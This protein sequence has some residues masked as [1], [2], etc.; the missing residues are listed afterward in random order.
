[1]TSLPS[2]TPLNG[3]TSTT[4]S[5]GSDDASV[6]ERCSMLGIPWLEDAPKAEVDA[7]A[8]ITADVAVRL[9]VVPLRLEHNRLIVAMLDPLDSDAADEISTLTGHPVRRVGLEPNHFSDLMRD[10][11]GTTAARMA[12]SLAGDSD[13]VADSDHNLDAIDA[14]DIHRMAEQPT[15]INLVNLI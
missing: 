1:M 13:D 2:E 6:K 8:M 14:D 7:V 11:Y 5:T 3:Q 10:H 4:L 9:R 15:L 12:E